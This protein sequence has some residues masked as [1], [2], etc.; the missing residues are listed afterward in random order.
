VLAVAAVAIVA[1]L[2][3]PRPIVRR[4]GAAALGIAFLVAAWWAGHHVGVELKWWPG[5]AACEAA[6]AGDLSAASIAEAL[7]Q[8]QTVV[9]CEDVTWSLL[10]I[11]MAGW[12]GLASTALA[13]ASFTIAALDPARSKADA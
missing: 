2:L 3:A 6:G 10:G 9:R 8:A 7:G 5:P 4:L 12:N 1:A 11:S 13:I